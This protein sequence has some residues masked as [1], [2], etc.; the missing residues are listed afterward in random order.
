AASADPC[1]APDRPGDT[2]LLDGSCSFDRAGDDAGRMGGAAV[3]LHVDR[4][5]ALRRRP[6]GTVPADRGP[7]GCAEPGSPG[8]PATERGPMGDA[9][10][11]QRACGRCR[12]PGGVRVRYGRQ[13]RPGAGGHE[14]WNRG[15]RGCGL[16]QCIPV[17]RKRVY[18][19][20]RWPQ[21]RVECLRSLRAEVRVECLR[22]LRAEVR[23]E[24]LP[25][26]PTGVEHL[27]GPQCRRRVEH[28][29][30]PRCGRR[31]V[32]STHD[33]GQRTRGGDE[34]RLCLSRLGRARRGR[35]AGRGRHAGRW[36]KCPLV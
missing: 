11:V 16:R 35:P 4:P 15:H 26:S 34:R 9:T 3:D 31:R 24:C 17:G 8:R 13:R 20:R 5:A 36:R 1:I 7:H 12:R 23:V 25:E 22:S 33:V 19:F 14:H 21:V 29:R 6:V 30:D 27:C 18:R 32:E 10:V 28:V 2:A